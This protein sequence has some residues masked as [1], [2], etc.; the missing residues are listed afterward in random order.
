MLGAEHAMKGGIGTASLIGPG[1]IVVGAIVANNAVGSVMRAETG[2]V[3][4]G[5]RGENPGH[6]LPYNEIVER[7]AIMIEEAAAKARAE[8]GSAVD[9]EAGKNTVL[10]AVATNAKLEHHHLQRVAYLAQDGLARAVL[11]A[12]TAADGDTAFAVSMGALEIPAHEVMTVGLLAN[13]AT[14]IAL[15]RSVT[16]SASAYGLP[17]NSDW[18]ASAP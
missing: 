7:R 11:P 15:E 4:A 16:Q 6:F 17:A 3:L 18:R 10:I 9:S 2:A 14:G 5:P 1:G 12:H 13:L 8:S